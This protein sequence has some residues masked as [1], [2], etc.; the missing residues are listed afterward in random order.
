MAF[1]GYG[2]YIIV[3]LLILKIKLNKFIDYD[4]DI[5]TAIFKI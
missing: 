5:T 4:L 1:L 3:K 2:K